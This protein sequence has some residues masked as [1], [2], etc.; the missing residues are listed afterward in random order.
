MKVAYPQPVRRRII[1]PDRRAGEGP[2]TGGRI[3]TETMV[4]IGRTLDHT[5][6]RIATGTT[7]RIITGR[8]TT[9]HTRMHI[10][11]V[12]VTTAIRGMA[13]GTPVQTCR[14]GTGTES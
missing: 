9:T 12:T 1:S 4:T 11:T 3:T 6:G 8:T 14:F 10:H 13:S 5:T 7:D 2:T